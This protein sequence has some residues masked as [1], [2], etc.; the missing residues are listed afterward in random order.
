MA[1]FGLVRVDNRLAHGMVASNWKNTI[2][3]K[4]VIILDD[5]TYGD[6]P[7]QK[8]M[9]IGLLPTPLVTYT[10]KGGVDK[11]KEN[12][13][14]GGKIFLLFKEVEFAYEAWKLGVEIP[15]LDI[16]QVH[17]KDGRRP[18][19]GTVNLSEAEISMLREM[20][21]GGVRVYIKQGVSDPEIELDEIEK[22]FEKNK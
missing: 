10:V 22:I 21:N 12:K 4:K 15:H 20:Q 18:I 5:E 11:Y 2:N 6:K 3:P 9:A 16:G 8:V 19:N 13:F 7:I 17:S 14:G 1:A